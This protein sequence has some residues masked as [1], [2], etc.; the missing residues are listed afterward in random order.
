MDGMEIERLVGDLAGDE[1]RNCS[2]LNF[3]RDNRVLS[4]DRAGGS[5]LVRGRSD[6]D[7]VYAS[8]S[9]PAELGLLAR[10][11]SGGDDYFAAIE[12][13]MVPI[14][15]RDREIA[16]SLPMVRFTLPDRAALP[17]IDGATEALT[18]G[19]ASVVYEHSDYAEFISLDYA[20]SRILAGPALGVREH[21]VLAAWG[22][23]QDDGAMGFLHVI[24]AYRK[25]G[26]GR[27]IT[28]ALA[29]E[30]RRRD[31]LP[32]AYISEANH[33]AIALVTALGFERG[34]AVRWFRLR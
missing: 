34:E 10:R 29:A 14:L 24:D 11:L 1:I 5:V 3:V 26:Y 19:D 8:S 17:E 9:D 2:I 32:F 13:W 31:R 21:G 28:I 22:M 20:R 30:L 27:R 33:G 12:P 6:Q 15:R 7:W 16:W 25:K 4:V 23:T 18:P